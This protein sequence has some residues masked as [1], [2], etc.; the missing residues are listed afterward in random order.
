MKPIETIEKEIND[1]RIVGELFETKIFSNGSTPIHARI[2]F[3]NANTGH[4]IGQIYLNDVRDKEALNVAVE[5]CG[6]DINDILKCL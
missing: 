6:G 2:N 3:S 5:G 1:V 4:L